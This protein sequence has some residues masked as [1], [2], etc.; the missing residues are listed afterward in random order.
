MIGSARTGVIVSDDTPNI[1]KIKIARVTATP[2]NPTKKIIRRQ[3]FITLR[4]PSFLF[5][6][7]PFGSVFL[8]LL[9]VDLLFLLRPRYGQ[10]VQLQNKIFHP[11]FDGP[12]V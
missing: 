3:E 12:C 4:T 7:E 1:D 2:V 11:S 10:L 6:F 9:F 5:L 8:S